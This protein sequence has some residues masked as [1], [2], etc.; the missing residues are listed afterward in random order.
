MQTHGSQTISTR[1]TAVGHV[2]LITFFLIAVAVAAVSF[3]GARPAAAQ[4]ERPS[5]STLVLYVPNHILDELVAVVRGTSRWDGGLP[6]PVPELDLTYKLCGDYECICI[7]VD[8]CEPDSDHQG[9][10][11]IVLASSVRTRAVLDLAARELKSGKYVVVKVCNTF[12]TL[13]EGCV[14]V[15]PDKD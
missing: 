7:N 13:H 8:P 3:G 4:V 15:S 12:Q 10:D 9:D 6:I 1:L 2:A 11:R 14:I 5:A